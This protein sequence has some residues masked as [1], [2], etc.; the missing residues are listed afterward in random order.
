MKIN[1]KLIFSFFLLLGLTMSARAL[2]LELKWPPSP[3]GTTLS[4]TTSFTEF[5]SYAYEWGIALGGVL[6]FGVLVWQG[7]QFMTSGGDTGKLKHARER[8]TEAVAG[9]II[10]LGS[11]LI[12]N[13]INPQLTALKEP[14]LTNITSAWIN[15]ST[16]TSPEMF[17]SCGAVTVWPEVNF[18]G[19]PRTLGVNATTNPAVE[20]VKSATSSGSCALEFFVTGPC[21]GGESAKITV[22]GNTTSTGIANVPRYLR[23]NTDI[24]YY[25][26]WENVIPDCVLCR[27]P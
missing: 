23:D 26:A 20:H 15:I 4:S 24:D 16:S 7:F 19:L 8:M 1:K 11:F 13:T 27:D 12:L 21:L 2:A 10:L 9:L 5:V 6:T 17:G 3:A 14:T 25:D 18:G 22:N